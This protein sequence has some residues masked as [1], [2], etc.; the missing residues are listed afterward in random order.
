MPLVYNMTQE[1]EEKEPV[2]VEI[3]TITDT[4]N[5]LEAMKKNLCFHGVVDKS[6]EWDPEA[7]NIRIV[8]TGDVINRE[9]PDKKSLDYIFRLKETAPPTCSVEVLVGN[10]E[11]SYTL[12][13]DEPSTKGN[14]KRELISQM[15]LVTHI[16]PILFL[17]GY[18]TLEFLQEL[19]SY[20][21]LDE[22]IAAVNTNFQGA[23]KESMAG[24]HQKLSRYNYAKPEVPPENKP[25]FWKSMPKGYY[26]KNGK[27]VEALLHT[28]GI[29]MVVHGHASR[30]E[31]VQRMGEFQQFMPSILFVNN[32]VTIS[33]FKKLDPGEVGGNKWG[34]MKIKLRE[35]EGENDRVTEME[36][37]NKKTYNTLHNT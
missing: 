28:F 24:K 5:D 22:G 35:M 14:S 3:I 2:E 11:I 12:H 37:V 19:S 23:M 27:E 31:G 25:I 10:H 15:S 21:S 32:D 13:K 33:K 8:H 16:G 7:K 20:G 34:S 36:F 18:P 26:E 4:H 6:G 17:H 1:R 9:K 29:E 30:Q